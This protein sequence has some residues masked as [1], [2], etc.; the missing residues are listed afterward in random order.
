MSTSE[1][2]MKATAHAFLEPKG[3][4]LG[5]ASVTLGDGEL[6][7]AITK[8]RI[9]AGKNGPFVAMPSY[10]DGNEFRDICYPKTKE[11]REALNNTVMDAYNTD[12]QKKIA[13][14]SDRA[15]AR[16]TREERPSATAKLD[17]AK[18][19]VAAASKATPDKAA[20]QVGGDAL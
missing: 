7:F 12:I 18:R 1:I 3:N 14:L 10:K 4:Q 15:A 17:A 8:I 19:E 6:E 5:F 20:P 13:G 9:M 2:A 16:D 11:G